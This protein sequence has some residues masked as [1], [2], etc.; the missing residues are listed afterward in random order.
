MFEVREIAQEDLLSL[1]GLYIKSIRA[2]EKGF[3]QD[4]SRSKNIKDFVIDTQVEGGNFMGIFLNKNL[5]GFGGY[6]NEGSHKLQICKL[7]LQIE[8]QGLGLGK[9]LFSAL[10]SDAKYKGFKDFT[11]HVT[12]TQENAVAM[13][14]KLGYKIED[15]K[16]YEIEINGKICRYPTLYMS[17]RY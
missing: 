9:L 2:N 12:D 4:L 10:E 17:K 8:Y 13:Y 6:V 7:H 15:K 3:I 1:E 11:L 5:I 16:N 14:Q